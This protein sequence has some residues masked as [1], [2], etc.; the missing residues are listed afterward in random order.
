MPIL[1][2]PDDL[3]NIEKRSQ[4]AQRLASSPGF[5]A[6]LDIDGVYTLVNSAKDV[7]IML[8]HLRS[9]EYAIPANV[10]A[11]DVEH[12]YNCTGPATCQYI[13]ARKFQHMVVMLIREAGD[14]DRLLLAGV[15]PLHA[16]LVQYW[17]DGAQHIV[18]AVANG[19]TL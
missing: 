11:R 7:I 9:A 14:L 17:E 15:Y 18:T 12:S 13:K 10:A 19:A 5:P 16:R 3:V 1:L 8:E 6:G 2:S 4:T